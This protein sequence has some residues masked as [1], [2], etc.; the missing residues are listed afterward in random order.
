MSTARRSFIELSE[1]SNV[2]RTSFEMPAVSCM[3][4]KETY[5]NYAIFKN[6]FIME[7]MPY[8]K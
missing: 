4:Y 5:G 3:F 2:A 7:T 6:K 8:I 1:L